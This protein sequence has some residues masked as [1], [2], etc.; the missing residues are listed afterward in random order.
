ML[1]HTVPSA[2]PEDL[3]ELAKD[4]GYDL[5]DEELEAINGGEK[6]LGWKMTSAP[7]NELPLSSITS[8]YDIESFRWSAHPMYRYCA[9]DQMGIVT[10]CRSR[11]DESEWRA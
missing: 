1:A 3:I 9:N 5:S 11:L 8:I 6:K 10:W 7:A 4:E 2:T